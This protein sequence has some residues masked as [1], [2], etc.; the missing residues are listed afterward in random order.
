M[1]I[2]PREGFVLVSHQNIE[3]EKKQ[4]CII[5]PENDEK[6]TYL[7]L[8][9]DGKYYAKGDCVF[10]QPFKTKMQIDENLFLIDENDIV[11]RFEFEV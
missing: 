11:A 6:K 9:S 7:R 8:E 3:K 10:L 5:L 2:I 4:G 1:K